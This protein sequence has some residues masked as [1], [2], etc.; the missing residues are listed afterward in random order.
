MKDRAP[1]KMCRLAAP[2]TEY[3]P[4]AVYTAWVAKIKSLIEFLYQWAEFRAGR[5]TGN[6]GWGALETNVTTER[7][8]PPI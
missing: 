8:S 3:I 6:L 1:G 5:V 7:M 2:L 4:Q